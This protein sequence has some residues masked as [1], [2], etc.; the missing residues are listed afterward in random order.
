MDDMK[1]FE[2]R[3]VRDGVERVIGV[4]AESVAQ[5]ARKVAWMFGPV[6]IVGIDGG[7]I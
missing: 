1:Y 3:F 5:V 7:R 6:A 2:C 4:V